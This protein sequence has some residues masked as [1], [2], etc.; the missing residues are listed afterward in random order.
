[1]VS[2][3]VSVDKTVAATKVAKADVSVVAAAAL[4]GRGR[5]A[6]FSVA[7]GVLVST[8]KTVDAESLDCVI[9]EIS[10]VDRLSERLVEA[11]NGSASD[12][13]LLCTSI[14]I[15]SEPPDVGVLASVEV[16]KV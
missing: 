14:L 9:G 13:V 5:V 11:D 15:L 7:V 8:G 2:D 6:R 3:T 4:V 16:A 12:T 1:M 10:D